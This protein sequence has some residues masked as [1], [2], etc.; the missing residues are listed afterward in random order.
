M[1]LDVQV[2]RRHRIYAI[3][4]VVC[5]VIFLAASVAAVYFDPDSFPNPRAWIWGT[6]LFWGAWLVLSIY[7]LLR[8]FRFRVI[9]SEQYIERIGAFSTL[10]LQFVDLK[11]ARWSCFPHAGSV[12]LEAEQGRIKIEF[13]F[14]EFAEREQVASWLNESVDKALQP[15]WLEFR[16]RVVKN[17]LPKGEMVYDKI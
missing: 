14:F 15:G 1:L 13:E 9:C 3:A 6:A 8:C 17:E 5:F 11:N 4:M 10:R 12:C 16:E 7:N 2:A